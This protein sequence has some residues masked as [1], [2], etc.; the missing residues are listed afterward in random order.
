MVDGGWRVEGR[1]MASGEQRLRNE[2]RETNKSI[3][4]TKSV[5][6]RAPQSERPNE[7]PDL[8]VRADEQEVKR[9]GFVTKDDSPT[10]TDAIFV[11]AFAQ[12]SQAEVFVWFAESGGQARDGGFHLAL[13]GKGK[14]IQ[15]A[16]EGSRDFDLHAALRRARRDCRWTTYALADSKTRVRPEA[17]SRSA[18]AL[19]LSAS[20][21]LSSRL[22]QLRSF[23]R[24]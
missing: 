16:I 7:S 20:A 6:N 11:E 12:F 2:E 3:G 21:S 8:V 24:S 13:F 15:R 5:L 19:S 1:E 14:R 22:N 10:K 17:R 23:R 4:E 9:V 18:Q